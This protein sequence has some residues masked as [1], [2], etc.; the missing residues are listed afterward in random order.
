MFHFTCDRSFIAARNATAHSRMRTKLTDLN[1][2]RRYDARGAEIAAIT[3]RGYGDAHAGPTGS[4][5]YDFRRAWRMRS[6]CPTGAMCT[7]DTASGIATIY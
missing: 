6:T 3:Q 5:V 1:V 7:S 2:A 4:A